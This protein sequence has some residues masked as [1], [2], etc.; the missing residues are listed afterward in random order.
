M[1]VGNV[2]VC[3]DAAGNDPCL[4]Y[5]LSESARF[6]TRLI[7]TLMDK[8]YLMRHDSLHG[9]SLERTLVYAESLPDWDER[10]FPVESGLEYWI[11][12]YLLTGPRS[13]QEIEAYLLQN[14]HRGSCGA[15]H[16]LLRNREI[17]LTDGFK[18]QLYQEEEE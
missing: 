14:G 7:K 15:L 13:L 1:N 11:K 6:A 17:F 18:Y 10:D 4:S 12:D 9:P 3:L 16:Q 8:E 5:N 2:I